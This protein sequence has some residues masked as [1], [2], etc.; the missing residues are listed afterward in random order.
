MTVPAGAMSPHPGRSWRDQAACRDCDTEIFFPHVP[1]GRRPTDSSINELW[2]KAEEPAKAICRRCRVRQACLDWALETEVPEGV[3]GGYNETERRELLPLFRARQEAE[4]AIRESQK[5]KIEPKPRELQILPQFPVEVRRIPG[6]TK[7][8]EAQPTANKTASITKWKPANPNEPKPQGGT[9]GELGIT[10]IEDFDAHLADHGLMTHQQIRDL[11]AEEKMLPRDREPFISRQTVVE[12]VGR[13]GLFRRETVVGNI[14]RWKERQALER[15]VQAP[16][17]ALQ[18]EPAPAPEAP[19]SSGEHLSERNLRRSPTKRRVLQEL[20]RAEVREKSGLA[21]TKLAGQIGLSRL[22][23]SSV[24][25]ELQTDGLIERDTNGKRTQRIA[26]TSLGREVTA[27]L[28]PKPEPVG[29]TPSQEPPVLEPGAGKPPLDIIVVPDQT[30]EELAGLSPWPVPQPAAPNGNGHHASDR[31]ITL[32]RP[33]T[34]QV[35]EN[36]VSLS[37]VELDALERAVQLLKQLRRSETW[38]QLA[39]EIRERILRETV[40]E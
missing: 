25:P 5:P 31:V 17:P 32:D 39:L 2:Q 37:G 7:P 27:R 12:K 15:A 23:V 11:L 28:W 14:Q 34:V 29:E 26:I 6:W 21:A 18:P 35:V 16:V 4:A 30:K 3:F 9:M 10:D 24:L 13:L 38:C 22:S 8:P 19:V 20:C 36:L 1:A 40:A 33:S